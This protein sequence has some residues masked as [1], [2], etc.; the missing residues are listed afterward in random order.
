MYCQFT[1]KSLRKRKSGCGI[2]SL[3]I[4]SQTTM[5]TD[6]LGHHQHN[7]KQAPVFHR[8]LDIPLL[9]SDEE[10]FASLPITN[11]FEECDKYGVPTGDI[12][13]R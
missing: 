11:W 8:R 1:W 9:K 3:V 13:Q 4:H 2:P 10:S 5:D 6:Q 7:K 12:Q